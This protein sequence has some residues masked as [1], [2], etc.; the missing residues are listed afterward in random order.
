M[1]C[2]ISSRLLCSV[3]RLKKTLE[4]RVKLLLFT[5]ARSCCLILFHAPLVHFN[6]VLLF[7]FVSIFLMSA[8]RFRFWTP[9]SCYHPYTI[10]FFIHVLY[11][12]SCMYYIIFHPYTISFFIHVLYHFF[13]FLFMNA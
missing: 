11:H 12:F 13:C 8:P 5:C 6:I 9:R 4:T 3:L 1:P 7:S 10:S 2:L